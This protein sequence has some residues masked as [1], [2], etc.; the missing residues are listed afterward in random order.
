MGV[1]A[2]RLGT[3]SLA[4]LMSDRRLES[5]SRPDEVLMVYAM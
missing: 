4:K 5:L 1:P 3:A 2:R